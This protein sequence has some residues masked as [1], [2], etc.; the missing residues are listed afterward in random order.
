MSSIQILQNEISQFQNIIDDT[1]ENVNEFNYEN[2]QAIEFLS[3]ID[4]IKERIE[5][6]NILI[7]EINKWDINKDKILHL[8]NNNNEDYHFNCL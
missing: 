8:F 3:N 6:S 4:I 2:N 5:Y 1:L 7:Q